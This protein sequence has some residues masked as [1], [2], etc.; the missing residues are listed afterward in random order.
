MASKGS[1]G[2]A[3]FETVPASADYARSRLKQE[4]DN[5][6]L[7]AQ[8]MR[9]GFDGRTIQLTVLINTDE[10]AREIIARIKLAAAG[11]AKRMVL[12]V[13]HVITDLRARNF[14]RSIRRSV[15]KTKK[16]KGGE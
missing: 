4:Q 13:A 12:V 16:G 6:E 2:N 8:D 10:D 3:G 11:P 15:R 7:E 1:E 5:P 14:W 9:L